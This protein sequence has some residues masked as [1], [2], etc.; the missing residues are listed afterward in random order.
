MCKNI[1]QPFRRWPTATKHF[2]FSVN[3]LRLSIKNGNGEQQ[4]KKKK[5]LIFKDT[6]KKFVNFWRSTF[7][8]V[9]YC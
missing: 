7:V 1:S 3:G 2:Q 4:K 6:G 8:P 9:Q 5:T